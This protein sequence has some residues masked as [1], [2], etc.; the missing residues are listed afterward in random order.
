[1]NKTVEVK[2]MTKDALSDKITKGESFR[3]IN[4]LDPRY[5]SLGVIKGSTL[6]P[7]AELEQRCSELDKSKEI[8]TYCA[9][10]SC[11]ASRKAAAMLAEKGFDVSVYEGGIKE[12]TAAK[13]PIEEASTP[14]FIE[15]ANA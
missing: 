6:I 1:M 4:V 15:E 11:S 9:D 14:A 8:V 10:A 5:Y 2:V 7:L 3:L 12:W 13:L